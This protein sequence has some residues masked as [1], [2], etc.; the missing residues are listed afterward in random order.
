MRIGR[1]ARGVFAFGAVAALGVGITI[2]VSSAPAG[3]DTALCTKYVVDTYASCAGLGW[4]QTSG[5]HLYIQDR[6]ADGHSVSVQ[7]TI[8]GVTKIA[9]NSNSAQGDVLDVVL[10]K[11]AGSRVS[12]KVCLSNGGVLAQSSCSGYAVDYL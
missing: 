5:D 8:A 12:Y 1:Q 11:T 3:A 6:V 10:P 2:G 7:Y 9:T 4:F